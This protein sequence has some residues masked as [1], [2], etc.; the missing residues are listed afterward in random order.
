MGRRRLFLIA[1]IGLAGLASRA[2]WCAAQE[3]GAPHAGPAAAHAAEGKAAHAESAPPNIL[4]GDLGNVF[5]TMTIFVVLLVLLRFTAW[6]PILAAL[7]AR[8]D[9]IRDSLDSAKRERNE[10]ER[11]LKEYTER[12]ERARVEASAIVEEGKRDA[13]AVR[14]RVHEETKKEADDMLARAKREI[15]VARDDAVKQLYDRTLTLATDVAG[16]IVKR[17]LSPTD[18]KALLD[19]AIAEM[20]GK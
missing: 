20:A 7:K 12:I 18:H 3:H 10:A 14:R 17:Q 13:E 6:K 4:S 2:A 8:E 16:K 9:F 1:V 15:G 19:E 5:W 11:L